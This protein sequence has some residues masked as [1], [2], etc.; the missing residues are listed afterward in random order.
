MVAAGAAASPGGRRDLGGCPV[1]G[2]TTV[3]ARPLLSAQQR[4]RL[5]ALREAAAVLS[6]LAVWLTSGM[7]HWPHLH[8]PGVSFPSL[9][10]GWGWWVAAGLAGVLGLREGSTVAVEAA[11]DVDVLLLDKTGKKLWAGKLPSTT[12]E[13]ERLVKP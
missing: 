12:R 13:I 7:W 11:G 4:R 8:V 10:L 2:A 6:G 5:A 1:T 9:S 3:Q